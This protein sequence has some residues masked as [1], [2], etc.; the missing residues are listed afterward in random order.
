MQ[1]PYFISL[2]SFDLNS[3]ETEICS[4]PTLPALDCALNILTRD[5]QD[6]AIKIVDQSMPAR[7]FEKVMPAC[8]AKSVNGTHQLAAKLLVSICSTLQEPPSC[9]LYSPKHAL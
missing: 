5:M 6:V 2:G 4:A 7:L 3:A 1:V 8:L 9:I